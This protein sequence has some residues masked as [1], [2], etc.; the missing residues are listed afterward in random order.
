MIDVAIIGCGVV[1][2]ATA[3]ELSRY[4]LRVTVLEAENDIADGTTKANSAILHAG[5]DPEPGTQMAR[6]N[7]RGVALAQEICARLDVPYRRCGSFVVAFSADERAHLQVLYERGIANGVPE[8]QLLSGEEARKLEPNLSVQ[9]VAALY[10]PS[11][12]I[13]GPW[14]YALAMAEVAVRNGVELR[15]SWPITQVTRIE[16]GY[17]LHSP[18]GVLDARFVI[19]ASGVSAEKI[20]NFI[21]KPSFHIVPTRG[22]Y[23]LLDKSEGDRVQHVI[24]Q[25]P[26]ETG[27]GVLVAPTVHGN[28]IVGPNAQILEKPSTACT[29][30]GLSF[31]SSSAKKSVPSIA[32]GETIRTFAGVRANISGDFIIEEAPDAP[33]WIDLAGIKSPGLSAAPAI[34]EEVIAILQR[35]QALPKKKTDYL[36]GRKQI[37]FSNLSLAEKQALVQKNP[38]YGRVICRCVTITEGEILAAL[39]SEIPAPSIDGVKRRCGAGMGRCQGGFCGPRILEMMCREYQCSPLDILQDKEGTHVLVEETKQEVHHV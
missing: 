21:A 25:C 10:A 18:K 11:A 8:L 15:R 13:V 27:K 36:D 14:E 23:Y 6:L 29:S 22:E 20:H 32:F 31:V 35:K 39:R 24:F 19:N 30:K 37:R 33:G 34:A 26:N 2:A 3:Y 16:G 9:V 4:P 5:Y 1:G 17:Q 12:A 7:V 38:T 28:L